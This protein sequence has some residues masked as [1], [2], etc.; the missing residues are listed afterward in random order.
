VG[1]GETPHCES[2]QP[3]QFVQHPTQRPSAEH[4]GEVESGQQQLSHGATGVTVAP[5]GVGVS[6]G[7]WHSKAHVYR[8]S[9]GFSQIP[10]LRNS[11]EQT[12]KQ[13][14]SKTLPQMPGGGGVG[15][16]VGGPPVAVNVG[17][18]Y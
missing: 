7:V 18:S 15:V 9:M 2:V 5:I 10:Y 8:P 4:T 16:G 14:L 17:P 6:V 1:V 11:S 3:Y 13:P 12:K